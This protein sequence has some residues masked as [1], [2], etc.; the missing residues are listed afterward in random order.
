MLTSRLSTRLLFLRGSS[1]ATY[2]AA[3]CCC[4]SC[5]RETLRL[6]LRLLPCASGSSEPARDTEAAREPALEPP[7]DGASDPARDRARGWFARLSRS[8]SP[9]E[10]SDL[11][12]EG[13]KSLEW[14]RSK[15]AGRSSAKLRNDGSAPFDAFG[16]W[17]QDERKRRGTYRGSTT[18][19]QNACVQCRSSTVVALPLP[20][21]FEDAEAAFSLKEPW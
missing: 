16:N 7:T 1:A 10:K 13:G 9:S 18:S 15:C 21:S 8:D 20:L 6:R 11:E 4:C 19:I 14:R 2:A 5:A 12:G 3:C 17:D